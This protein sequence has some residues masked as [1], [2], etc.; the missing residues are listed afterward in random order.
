[1]R[2]LCTNNLQN[3]KQDFCC[4]NNG[5]FCEK[6][7]R[8]LEYHVFNMVDTD[9]GI[10]SYV[11]D[12]DGSSSTVYTPA[13]SILDRLKCPQLSELNRKRKRKVNPP[14]GVCKSTTVQHS[15]SSSKPK[16]IKLAD[17]V[18]EYGNQPFKVSN[19]KLFCEACREEL[20]LKST[21]IN[22]H[23]HSKKHEQERKGLKRNRF[24]KLI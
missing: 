14:R 12:D 20:N 13:I 16:S 3:N 6:I 8:S 1:M 22:N 23:I 5:C 9:C 15:S 11:D 10:S 4:K 24:V 7:G 19:S 21:V 17:R 2:K 18:R